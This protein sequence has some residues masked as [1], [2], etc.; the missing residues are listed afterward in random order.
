MV[1]VGI[2][3]TGWFS[4]VHAKILSNMQ[5][6]KI[7]AICGTSKEKAEKFASSYGDVNSYGNIA[8]MLDSDK[9]DAVYVCVPPFAHGEIELELLTREIP[10]LVEKPL[11]VDLEVPTKVITKLNE[12][13]I[14]TSVGYHFRYKDSVSYLKNELKNCTLGMATGEWMGSMP[15]VP[16]WRNQQT[17]GGQFIEQTTHLV[18]LL[19]YTIGEV[20]EVYASYASRSLST[21][22]EG[23][24]VADVGTVAIKFSSGVIANLSNTCLLPEGD[25][26]VGLDYYT[27][28]GILRLGFNGLEISKKGETSSVKEV[29]NPYEKENEAFIHAVRTGDPSLILSDYRDAYKTQEVAVAAQV[30]AE[31]GLPVKLTK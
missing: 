17:S 15:T 8:E 1:K 4:G 27:N 13:S 14:I 16:W 28:K 20:E 12:K 3:G 21:Q 24:T 19:R 29:V 31:K 26:M 5:G 30:S 25:S 22:Y 11:S 7:K 9:L 2:I 23:V 18:D 6:V 10:F